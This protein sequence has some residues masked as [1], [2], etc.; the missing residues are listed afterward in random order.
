[1]S[2][3]KDI[4]NIDQQILDTE[5]EIR[6]LNKKL[7]NLYSEKSKSIRGMDWLKPGVVVEV[8]ENCT[9]HC[10]II[11]DFKFDGDTLVLRGNHISESITQI[12]HDI[13]LGNYNALVIDDVTKVKRVDV[14]DWNKMCARCVKM[15]TDYYI[16]N[17]TAG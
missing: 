17:A 8:Q 14:S 10:M 5:L 12:Y 6:K 1:M 11:V 15:F 3:V 16:D 9:T 7:A 13:H 4:E 2:E